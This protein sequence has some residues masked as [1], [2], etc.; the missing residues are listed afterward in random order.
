LLEV[1]GPVIA[2]SARKHGI[3]DEDMLHAWRNQ[4]GAKYYD[5]G[6]TMVIGPDRAGS[7]RE[8]GTVDADDGS[9]LCTRTWPVPAPCGRY[10]ADE[11]RE[12]IRSRN[13]GDDRCHGQ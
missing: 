7:L 1:H 12:Q 2:G 11:D 10:W 3:A 13:Q 9:S 4:I 8:V 6:F 5:D